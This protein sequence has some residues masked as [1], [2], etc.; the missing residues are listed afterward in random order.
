MAIAIVYV[1][2]SMNSLDNS[3][4]EISDNIANGD[5]EYND[6]VNLINNKNYDDALEK[7][8]YASDNFNKSSR[9]LLVIQNSSDN[10]KEVHKEYI[11]T[12]ID[13]VEL[14]QD[15]ASNLVHAIYYFK[16]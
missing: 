16:N 7:A 2:F 12:I 10:F 9:D 14:K 6:A 15:A 8:L 13:E 3:M 4:A 11:V 5:K 1:G